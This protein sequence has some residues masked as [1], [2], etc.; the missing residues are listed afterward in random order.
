[1]GTLVCFVIS[2]KA[3]IPPLSSFPVIPS[4]SSMII[5]FLEFVLLSIEDN[6]VLFIKK[7]T[8]LL[9]V[10]LFLL[11]LAFNSNIRYPFVFAKILIAQ[12]FP[13]PEGPL[14][15]AALAFIFSFFPNFLKDFPCSFL[16]PCKTQS[17]HESNQFTKFLICC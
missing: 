7:P 6:V 3:L 9:I 10:S 2:I 13:I 4:I 11:S 17:F 16:C 8:E 12:V 15:I 14:I 5:I 1:M